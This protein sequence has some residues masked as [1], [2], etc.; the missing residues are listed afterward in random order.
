MPGLEAN[1]GLDPNEGFDPNDGFD[2]IAEAFFFAA[3][4]ISLASFSFLNFS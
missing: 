4:S 1:P 3:S 2:D